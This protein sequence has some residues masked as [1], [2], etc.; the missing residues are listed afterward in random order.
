MESVEPKEGVSAFDDGMYVVQHYSHSRELQV[1]Q[2]VP[3]HCIIGKG[4]RKV[5]EDDRAVQE[6]Y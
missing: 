6:L 1:E 3:R 2:H 4:N 5:P